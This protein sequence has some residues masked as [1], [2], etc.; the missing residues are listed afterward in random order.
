MSP[1]PSYVS[2]APFMPARVPRSARRRA[3]E[4]VAVHR[5][6]RDDVLVTA[7]AHGDLDGIA[8][9]APPEPLVELLL[10][11]HAHAVHGDDAVAAPEA[12]A[13]RRPGVVEPL[14]DDAV[15][16]GAREQAEPRPGLPARHAAGRDQLVLHGEEG[17]DRDGQVDVRRVAESQRDDP[18]ET[19]PVV[20]E[21]AAAP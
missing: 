10:G 12:G 6:H 11:G 17:L 19:P 20:D 18:D 8:G 7:A 2:A 21:G 16:G 9:P 4:R 14:D 1:R 3:I 13:A 5:A 15:A